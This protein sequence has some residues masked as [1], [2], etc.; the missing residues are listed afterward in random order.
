M[1]VMRLLPVRIVPFLQQEA[2]NA[3]DNRSGGK[4]NLR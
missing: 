3:E 1:Q 2:R 4:V